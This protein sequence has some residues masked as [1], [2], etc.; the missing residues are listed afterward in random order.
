MEVEEEEGGQLLLL[1]GV[2]EEEGK[3]QLL[4]QVEVE[5]EEAQLLIGVVG[6]EAGK[7]HLA[8]S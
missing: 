3:D 2:E 8:D 7:C 4:I 6:V 5:V 1:V